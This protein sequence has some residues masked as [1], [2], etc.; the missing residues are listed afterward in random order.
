MRLTDQDSVTDQPTRFLVCEL[1]LPMCVNTKY[2]RNVA[3][4]DAIVFRVD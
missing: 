2:G 4:T 3:A 1:S